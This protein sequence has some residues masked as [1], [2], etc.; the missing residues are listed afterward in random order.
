MFVISILGVGQEKRRILK[1]EDPVERY[2]RHSGPNWG[3]RRN[4]INDRSGRSTV[5]QLFRSIC[6]FEG[7]SGCGGRW[8]RSV[9]RL[10]LWYL[11]LVDS[12]TILNPVYRREEEKGVLGLVD[13]MLRERSRIVRRRSPRTSRHHHVWGSL[14]DFKY[15]LVR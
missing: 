9:T 12:K 10:L 6:R 5:R 13:R 7:R 3:G 4:K 1:K 11:S 2:P 15:Q 14:Q 8:N